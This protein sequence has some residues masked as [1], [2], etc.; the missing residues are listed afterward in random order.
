MISKTVKIAVSNKIF[1]KSLLIFRTLVFFDRNLE[2]TKV[3]ITTKTG[4]KSGIKYDCRSVKE[5]R[6]VGIGV[7]TEVGV[8][9]PG[10]GKPAD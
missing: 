3:A 8:K 10:V 1:N 9:T 5:N 2:I 6:G 4:V 7:I